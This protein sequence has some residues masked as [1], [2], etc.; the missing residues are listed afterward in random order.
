MFEEHR[1][2]PQTRSGKEQRN[3]NGGPNEIRTRVWV[4]TTDA[5]QTERP[6]RSSTRNAFFANSSAL[7]NTRAAERAYRSGSKR[8]VPSSCG[9]RAFLK[10][11]TAAEWRAA[12]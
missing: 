2:V 8:K 11:T 1:E 3:R 7:I 12:S 9:S 10:A 4:T 6:T 5:T